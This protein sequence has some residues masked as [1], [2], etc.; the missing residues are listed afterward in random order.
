[1]VVLV[2]LKVA[3][4]RQITIE[5]KVMRDR[6]EKQLKVIELEQK[7]KQDKEERDNLKRKFKEET[8]DELEKIEHTYSD[9]GTILIVKR[10]NFSKLPKV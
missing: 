8:A 7:E 9:A 4:P 3:T 1:V 2:P 10:P 5:E 6:K